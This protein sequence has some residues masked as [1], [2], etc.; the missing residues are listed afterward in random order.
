MELSKIQIEQNARRCLNCHKDF[1]RFNNA[2]KFCSKDCAEKLKKDKRKNGENK[3][4]RICPTCDQMFY[5][6]NA[7]RIL[8]NQ[9]FCSAKCMRREI[10]K[11][12]ICAVCRSE[13][14]SAS[15]QKKYCSTTCQ[16]K[17]NYASAKKRK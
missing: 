10:N 16:N 13:F 2:Q 8:K 14:T 12:G 9:K 7:K 15:A 11:S 4:A 5:I 6:V 1:I 3:S 17:A